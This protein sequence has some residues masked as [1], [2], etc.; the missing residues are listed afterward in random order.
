MAAR[1]HRPGGIPPPFLLCL[2]EVWLSFLV[3]RQSNLINNNSH[4]CNSWPRASTQACRWGSAG[5]KRA[6]AFACLLVCGE[7]FWRPARNS[8]R[9][10]PVFF[11][12]RIEITVQVSN[13]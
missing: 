9:R 4:T 6:C 12:V 3:H 11:L 7:S 1:N 2:G 10:A 13:H 8:A 5:V